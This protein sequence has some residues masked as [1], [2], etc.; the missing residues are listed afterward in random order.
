MHTV[1]DGNK[2]YKSVNRP[3]DGVDRIILLTYRVNRLDLDTGT[4]TSANWPTELQIE[5][6]KKWPAIPKYR[7]ALWQ[8][9][10]QRA[11]QHQVDLAPESS[12]ASRK[13]DCPG[14]RTVRLLFLDSSTGKHKGSCANKLWPAAESRDKNKILNQNKT[15]QC[16]KRNKTTKGEECKEGWVAWEGP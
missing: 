5:W 6:A 1:R 7:C 11:A 10:A 9:M 12:P 14:T 13:T 15:L 3:C 16:R 4:R 8:N 2:T